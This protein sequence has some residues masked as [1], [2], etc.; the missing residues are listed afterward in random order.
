[1]NDTLLARYAL[2]NVFAQAEI[3]GIIWA[4]IGLSQWVLQSEIAQVNP[5]S[6]PADVDTQR[7]VG[8]DLEQQVLVAYDGGQPMFAA[9]VATGLD[10]SPTTPGLFHVFFRT[11]ERAMS[12]GDI[13][14]PFYYFMEDVPYTMYFDDNHALHGAYWHDEFGQQRSHGCVN[15]SL[16]D[17]YWVYDFLSGEI[18]LDNPDDLWPVVYVYQPGA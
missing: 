18:D 2:V 5:I 10:A 8:V 9:L 1:M 17:A 13:N 16:T 7:W 14:A 11:H 4:Q 6:R 12:R 15:L 3:D